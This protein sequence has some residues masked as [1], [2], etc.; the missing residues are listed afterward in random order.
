M[1]L[2]HYFPMEE[3]MHT[4]FGQYGRS[5]CW[6]HFN[7]WMNFFQSTRRMKLALNI[8]VFEHQQRN[9]FLSVLFISWHCRFLLHTIKQEEA[10]EKKSNVKRQKAD[11]DIKATRHRTT[12]SP[13][14]QLYL[15]VWSFFPHM[16]FLSLFSSPTL[17]PRSFLLLLIQTSFLRWPWPSASL[18]W[19]ASSQPFETSLWYDASAKVSPLC[20]ACEVQSAAYYINLAHWLIWHHSS[21]SWE[22]GACSLSLSSALTPV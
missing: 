1:Y 19:N 12:V 21:L 7:L 6:K 22:F 11:S 5:K 4:G 16:A 2:C 8:L 13:Q 14:R 10:E 17:L 9:L 20:K 18:S 3:S 15:S